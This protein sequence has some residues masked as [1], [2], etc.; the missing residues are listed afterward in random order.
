[1]LEN[2]VG[3]LKEAAVAGLTAIKDAIVSSVSEFL[4]KEPN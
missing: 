2:M 3:M 1:V 4:S